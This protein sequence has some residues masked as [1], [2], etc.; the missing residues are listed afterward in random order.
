MNKSIM[1]KPLFQANL[2]DFVEALKIGFQNDD[3]D[4]VKP[5]SSGKNLVYG[6]AGLAQLLGCSQSTAQ[7]IKNSGVLD[8]AISQCGKII[9]IDADLTLELMK[10]NKGIKKGNA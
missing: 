6:L 1:N 3:E 4:T 9:V 8:S 2:A 7:R 5:V 10:E